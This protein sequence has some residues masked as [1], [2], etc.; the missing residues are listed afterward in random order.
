MHGNQL[1]LVPLS[2]VEQQRIKRYC[3]RGLRASFIGHLVFVSC[4]LGALRLLTHVREGRYFVGNRGLYDA[5]DQLR[6]TEADDSLSARMY[7]TFI[8]GFIAVVFIGFLVNFALTQL[9]R[10]RDWQSGSKIIELAEI[11]DI[12]T[13]PVGYVLHTSSTQ[14]CSFEMAEGDRQVPSIG[15]AIILAYYRHSNLFI[16]Y[17]W[18]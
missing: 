8:L 10:F 1:K 9:S 5:Y 2:Q 14:H 15:Q 13:T 7:Y 6:G 4:I 12:T 18:E 11:V 16:G 17:Y 3:L